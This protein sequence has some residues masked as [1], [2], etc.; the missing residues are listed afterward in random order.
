MN[1]KS[2]VKV[3]NKQSILWTGGKYHCALT[4]FDEDKALT[5]TTYLAFVFFS[6]KQLIEN[7]CSVQFFLNIT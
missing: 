7:Y 3:E 5:L 2:N 4:M 1:E 6:F